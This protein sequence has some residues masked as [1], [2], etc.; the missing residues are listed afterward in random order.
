M[1]D[2][3]KV[4]PSEG[5]YGTPENLEQKLDAKKQENLKESKDVKEAADAGRAAY[6]EAVGMDESVETTGK[7][8][9]VLSNTKEDSGDGSTGAKSAVAQMTP[10]QIK[11]QLLK[12]LPSEPVMRKQLETE[13]RK[14]IDYLHKKA[15][16]MVR[17]PGNISYFEMNNLMSKI[18]ELKGILL[19]LLKASMDTLKTLWLRYVHGIM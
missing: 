9:E 19:T 12:N 3:A 13:I 6:I 11:A 15:M 10:A 2:S 1:S 8:S 5:S 18:R 14:E 17:S 4:R 16:K 7:V